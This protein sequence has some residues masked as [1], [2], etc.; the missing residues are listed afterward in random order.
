MATKNE[1]P[2]KVA[3]SMGGR[4]HEALSAKPRRPSCQTGA[5]PGGTGLCEGGALMAC[6][7]RWRPMM[8]SPF[9]SRVSRSPLR[10]AVVRSR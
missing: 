8:I 5:L 7:S 9:G 4:W 3:G 2:A 10:T 6:R 1:N